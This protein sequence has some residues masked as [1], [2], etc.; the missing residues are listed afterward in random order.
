MRLGQ[1]RAALVLTSALLALPAMADT[2]KATPTSKE[3]IAKSKP[4][5]WRT[6][7]PENLLYMQLPQGRVVIELAPD[8]TPLHAQN[9]RTLVREHYFDG[10][11]IIRVQDN[12]VTQWGDPNDDDNGD[13]SKIKPLGTAKP[14]L[15]PEYTRSIDPKLPWTAL[16]DGDVYAPQVGFSEGFPVA[17][18]PA[19]GREWLVH[20]YGMVGVARDVAPDSGSGSSLY[21]VIGQAPRQ[22]D[23]NL[24]IAGRVIEGMPYLS[25]LPRGTG[26]LGFYTQAAQRTPILSVKVAADLPASQRENLQV[27][28]TDSATFAAIVEAKRNRRDAFYTLPAG[29]IGLCSIDVPVRTE[30]SAEAKH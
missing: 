12:F 27:L 23:R 8:F 28:R 15:A 1:L 22:I 18:D 6:P 17:R 9:I 21:T 10:L 4:A 16:P 20:C 5:E 19:K 25:A 30:T 13:K 7:D 14:K 24:A 2:T 29:K 11:A 26:P 3:L